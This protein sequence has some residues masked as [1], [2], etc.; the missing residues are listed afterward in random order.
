[1]F[2]FWLTSDDSE[3]I[4][5]HGPLPPFRRSLK[6]P[7]DLSHENFEDGRQVGW[8]A[9]YDDPLP[10]QPAEPATGAKVAI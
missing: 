4:S 1:M 9:T 8:P 6:L 5:A 10:A 7:P 2:R 3:Q